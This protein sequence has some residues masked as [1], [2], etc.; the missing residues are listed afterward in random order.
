MS[1]FCFRSISWGHNDQI[2]HMHWYWQDL[3][4]D[5]YISIFAYLINRVMSEFLLKQMDGFWLSVSWVDRKAM[6]RNDPKF[7]D[8]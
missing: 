2:L 1:E 7:L 3:G 6:Y 5:S 4:G 8:R